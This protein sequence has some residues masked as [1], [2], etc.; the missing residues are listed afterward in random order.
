V[1]FNVIWQPGRAEPVIL[2][3]L[4]TPGIVLNALGR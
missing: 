3:E 4:L 2:P 1:P